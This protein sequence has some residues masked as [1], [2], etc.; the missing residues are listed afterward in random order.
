MA[1]FHF[2]EDA[3]PNNDE[4]QLGYCENCNQFHLTA[5]PMN[6]SFEVPELA[7]F[8][9][10]AMEVYWEQVLKG[11]APMPELNFQLTPQPS[12]PLHPR[13]RRASGMKGAMA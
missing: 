9:G 4:I 8:L 7:E 5:G 3:D 2:D 1:I 10:S 6:L 12:L 11:R 13:T